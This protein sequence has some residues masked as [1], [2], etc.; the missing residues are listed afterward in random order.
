M[1]T[2][3]AGSGIS[4]DVY[5][6][7]NKDGMPDNGDTSFPNLTIYLDANNNGKLD[8]GE[9]TTVTDA[10]GLYHFYG[11]KPGTY[12][13]RQSLPPGFYPELPASGATTVSIVAHKDVAGVEFADVKK[14]TISGRVF[15]DTNGNHKQD[16]SEKGIAGVTLFIDANKNGKK[17]LGEQ[18]V[19][20]DSLGNYAFGPL[21]AGTYRVVEKLPIGFKLETPASGYVD[22]VV[23]SASLVTG[24]DFADQPIVA[25]AEIIQDNTQAVFSG[26]WTTATTLPGFYGSNY[27]SADDKD[28]LAKSAKFSPNLPAAG[29][30]KVYAR[31]G[32]APTDASNVQIDIIHKGVK[33]TVTA[34]QRID[35]NSWVLLGTYSFDAG[36]TGTVTLR[37]AGANGTVVA[38]AVRFVMS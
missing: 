10:S 30:Y 3:T 5:I 6:D 7:L 23:G 22:V 29:I 27:R 25:P 12:H 36:S 16:A 26:N 9:Q 18:S 8:A 24:K 11:L 21:A 35:N 38:D 15:N 37:T 19:V 2:I 4:G 32:A 20:T 33:T 34:N 14:G 17:D 28:K 31:W 1:E 13:V